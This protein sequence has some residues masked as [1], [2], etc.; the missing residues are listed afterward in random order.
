MSFSK[1]AV[2]FEDRYENTPGAWVG[3]QSTDTA[4][5]CVAHGGPNGGHVRFEIVGEEKLERVSGRVLPVE[6][7]VGA[8]K[9]IDFTITYRGLLPS[10]HAEDI[11]VTATFTENTPDAGPITSQAKLTCVKVWLEAV[12]TAP[13]FTNDTRHTYGIAEEIRYIS[14]PTAIAVEWT[15]PSAFISRGDGITMCP[16]ST[17]DGSSG[18]YTVSVAALNATY[19]ASVRVLEPVIVT[20]NIRVNVY[21]TDVSPQFGESGHL[22]LYQDLYATPFYVSFKDVQ[23]REI[24]DESQSC[25][26]QGYYDDRARGGIGRT[27]SLTAQEHGT[28]R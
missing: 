27:R 17:S 13:A 14:N 25:P 18:F 6:Q 4:L 23:F 15:F 2:I 28:Q 24:P 19:D 1:S 8:G 11:V 22:L 20:T 26:H 3:R 9:K 5:H 12:Q 7:D 21:S 16:W 10:S